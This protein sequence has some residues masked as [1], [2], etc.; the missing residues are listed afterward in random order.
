MRPFGIH[1]RN[2]CQIAVNSLSSLHRLS[3][4]VYCLFPQVEK[5]RASA[6]SVRIVAATT[7][8]TNIVAAKLIFV[9]TVSSNSQWVGKGN[10]QG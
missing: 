2:L 4:A 8:V 1:S 10:N 6:A 3:L 9:H 7:A 5:S